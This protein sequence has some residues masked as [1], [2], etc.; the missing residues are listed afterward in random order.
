MRPNKF[1]IIATLAIWLSLFMSEKIGNYLSLKI[2]LSLNP[3]LMSATMQ[4]IAQKVMEVVHGPAV[5]SL[6]S[7]AIATS[8]KWL[9]AL[10]VSYVC[11]VVL[12]RFAEPSPPPEESNPPFQRTA[13]QPLN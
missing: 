12:R 4:S 9:F 5:I 13:T 10:L 7:L 6:G 3:G 8:A 11:A 1:V 2:M